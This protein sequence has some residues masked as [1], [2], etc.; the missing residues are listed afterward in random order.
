MAPALCWVYMFVA[1]IIMLNLVV[2][3]MT[4]T[5]F[6]ARPRPPAISSRSH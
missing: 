3:I 6:K 1:D 2:A 4:E 5:Y